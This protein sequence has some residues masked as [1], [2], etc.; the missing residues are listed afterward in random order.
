M[1]PRQPEAVAARGGGRPRI[2]ASDAL[3]VIAVAGVVMIHTT[4]W[5]PGGG[6]NNSTVFGA[7]SDISRFSVPVF[8]VLTG[9]ALGYQYRDRARGS[10]FIA[11]RGARTVVPWLVWAPIFIL[12]DVFVAGGL[13]RDPG[14]IIA[15][16]TQGAGHLWYLMLVPQFYLLFAIWPRRNA[17]AL[18]APA[19][20][21]Q[22]LLAVCR[23]YGFFS[24]GLQQFSLTYGFELFP[25]WIGY[26][27]LGVAVGQAVRPGVE[28]RRR[29]LLVALAALAVAGGGYLMLNLNYEGAAWAGFV[30][31]TGAFEDPALPLLVT[32]VFALG[33][34]VATPLVRSPRRARLVREL[35]DLSL[36]IYIVHPIP[37]YFFGRWWGSYLSTGGAVSYLA[38]STLG[39]AALAAGAVVSRLLAATPLALYI[40]MRP[41]PLTLGKLLPADRRGTAAV[42]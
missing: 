29:T 12:F 1:I 40:G 7:V 8:M 35:A 3:R 30:Q 15:W 33:W 23:V 42:R 10:G 21:L 31:G 32:G 6:G 22:T 26:F 9:F 17:W 38:L 24:T 11:R 27:A 14:S 28:V 19:L 20:L 2:V 18:V 37:L 39:L 16:V 4:A 13:G 34:L 25:F 36:G 41:K 5:A